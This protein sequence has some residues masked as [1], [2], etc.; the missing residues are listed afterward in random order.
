MLTP[1]PSLEYC[2]QMQ[3]ECREKIARDGWDEFTALGL[4][5]WLHEEILILNPAQSEV[6]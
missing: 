1:K 6:K 3:A 5:D 4:S 2:R